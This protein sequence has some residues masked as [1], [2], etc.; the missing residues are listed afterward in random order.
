MP[1]HGSSLCILITGPFSLKPKNW[2]PTKRN[3]G[4]TMAIVYWQQIK[5]E[6]IKNATSQAEIRVQYLK[7]HF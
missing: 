4:R 6:P 2:G 3:N 5:N 7:L 1:N